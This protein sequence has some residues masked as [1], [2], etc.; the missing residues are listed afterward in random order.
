MLFPVTDTLIELLQNIVTE[1]QAKFIIK[2]YNRKPNMNLDEIKK[3]S[4]LDDD[5]LTRML[6]KLQ[7]KGVIVGT[8]SK[9]TGIIVYRLQPPF[10]GMFEFQLM[11]PGE[12]EREKNLARL[13]DTIFKEMGQ[14]TSKNYDSLIP[15]FKN[16]PP[17]DRVI[18]VEKEVDSESEI[19]LAKDD[20]KRII[21]KYDDIAVALCYCRHDKYLIDEP[22]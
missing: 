20:V 21:D 22:F 18:P 8:Q 10:P 12:G 1:E 11:R 13:F 19:I 15:Q 17:V 5:S 3:K 14:L 4:D 7:Y 9:S 16:F 6:D 2:V